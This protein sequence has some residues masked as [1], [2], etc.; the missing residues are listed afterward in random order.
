M[1][2]A[3]EQG[4]QVLAIGNDEIASVLQQVGDLLAAEGADRYR[5]QAYRR[6][7]A[8][9]RSLE[10]PLS[11][12]DAEGGR[13]ALAELP[14]I[15]R[16]I[17]ASID[18][19]VHTGRLALLERLT[20]EAGAEQLF[21]TVPGIGPE[22][23]A[24]LHME[25]GAETLEQLEQAAHDGRLER[26][27]GIGSRKA[28]ALRDLLA[29]RLRRDGRLRRGRPRGSAATAGRIDVASLLA[30]DAR[31]RELARRGELAR[32]AP[33]RFNPEGKRW[34][35][36]LR[37]TDPR[38]GE[39]TAM[40]SNTARAHDLGRTGDWVVIYLERDGDTDRFT[41]VTEHSGKLRGLRIVRGRERECSAVYAEAG[42]SR[43]A[44]AKRGR[45]AGPS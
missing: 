44:S 34:L 6:A 43:E 13:R 39:V 17:A 32:I 21:T 20:G 14:S 28:A 11:E 37:E 24:R 7:A 2:A 12:I 19:L 29:E 4:C 45:S 18:E 23:A 27:P 38:W 5:V 41:V 10:R 26:V 3:V 22:L 36:V 1:D 40:F 30:I 31:Y 15:G 8:F 33:R 25:L 35:P 9:V 16:S 42:R